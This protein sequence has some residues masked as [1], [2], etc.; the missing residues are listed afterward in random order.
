MKVC[1]YKIECCLTPVIYFDI[2]HEFLFKMLS[3]KTLDI[4][5]V[6]LST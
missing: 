4:Y 2:F 6:I 1:K 5:V 3:T